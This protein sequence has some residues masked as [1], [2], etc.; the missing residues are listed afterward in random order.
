MPNY[1]DS[2]LFD[3]L[4]ITE[5]LAKLGH[6][7]VH[8][9]GKESFYHSMLR[10]TAHNTPSFCVWEDGGKWIDRGGPGL[11]NIAG[12]GIIQLG[13]ALWPRLSYVQVLH[14]I[15]DVFD[16]DLTRNFALADRIPIRPS[17]VNEQAQGF[18]LIRTKPP[19]THFVLDHY[20][21]SRGI[22]EVA[23]GRLSEVYFRHVKSGR[24]LYAI[25][26]SNENEGWEFANAKGFK[27][28]IGPKGLTVSDGNSRN[29]A[30]FESYFDYLSW[31]TLQPPLSLPTIIVLNSTSLAG[32]AIEKAATFAKIDLYLDRDGPGV[33]CTGRFLHAFPDA[34]DRSYEY[35]GF[36][37]YNE[38]IMSALAYSKTH[39]I[40]RMR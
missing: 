13:M 1:I 19:G 39:S 38:K 25:G 24:E 27:G 17:P 21:R 4:S 15:V 40:Y 28:S 29:V 37:D 11:S 3:S 2:S 26:W 7:P 5:F 14:A 35:E 33:K 12:G 9:Y 36:K 18:E 32:K 10:E 20:L 8:R 31:L 30:V 34:V 22:R 6:M 16:K 23:E